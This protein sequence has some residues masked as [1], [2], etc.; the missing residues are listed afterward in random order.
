MRVGRSCQAWASRCGLPDHRQSAAFSEV[1]EEDQDHYIAR[2]HQPCGAT[3]T[4]IEAARTG[5]DLALSLNEGG[6]F[7]ENGNCFIKEQTLSDHRARD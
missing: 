7:A 3:L 2:I 5:P 4:K 6:L 1:L